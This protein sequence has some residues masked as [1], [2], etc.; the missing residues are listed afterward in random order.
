MYTP[1]PIK[2]QT[3]RK[4]VISNSDNRKNKNG[5]ITVSALNVSNNTKPT[6]PNIPISHDYAQIT[7]KRNTNVS[8]NNTD[9]IFNLM[10][11]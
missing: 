3:K 10:K 9:D 8:N 4:R 6:V 11:M 1:S 2:Q 5:K 7:R